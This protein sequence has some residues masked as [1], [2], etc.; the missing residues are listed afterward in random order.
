MLI[1]R[2]FI[3]NIFSSPNK[4]AKAQRMCPILIF[5]YKNLHV[6]VYISGCRLATKTYCIL[7]ESLKHSDYSLFYQKI[8]FWVQINKLRAM[9][10]ALFKLANRSLQLK[11]KKGLKSPLEAKIWK[12]DP[13]G[14]FHVSKA[15]FD[16]NL[17]FVA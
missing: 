12:F 5:W 13:M 4:H 6:F 16:A 1:I 15:P 17:V 14:F 8:C 3:K 7:N 9:K 2:F 11:T 10:D